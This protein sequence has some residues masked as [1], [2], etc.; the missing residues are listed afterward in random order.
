LT[1][2]SIESL[3]SQYGSA[4][5]W[6]VTFTGMIAAMTMILSSTMVNVAVPSIMGSYGVGQDE[7]Q[8]MATAFLATMTASQLLGAWLIGALGY[9]GGYLSAVA[10]FIAG[11]FLCIVAPNIDLLI[12]GRVVQGFAAGLVQPVAM[13][14][15]FRVFP[16]ERRGLA[17]S[18][19]GMG[20][21]IAPIMGPVVGGVTIDA[22]GWRELFFIPLPVTVLALILGSIFFPTRDPDEA[23]P[24]F[25]WLGY[26]LLVVTIICL[27]TFIANGQREGWSSNISMMRMVVGIVCAAA[28]VST[29]LRSTSPLLDF[30]LFRHPQF[31]AAALLGFVFGAGNF[32]S[33]YAIPV[34]VQ[35][36]QYFSPTLAGMVTV[37]AGVVLMCLFPVGGRLVDALPVH[38]LAMGGLLVFAAGTALLN[39]ADANTAFWTLAIYVIVGRIGLSLLMPTIN[40]SAL[41]ALPAE[42]LNRGSGTIN[43][44]RLLGGACGVNG[45]VV[46]ME[47]RAEFHNVSLTA[48][49]TPGNNVS[50]ELLSKVNE[51]L[52]AA[53]VSAAERGPGALHYLGQVIEAQANTLGFQDGFMLLTAVFLGALLPAWI[54]GLSSRRKRR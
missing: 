24:P 50:Q 13:V 11:S 10:I 19:Y 51:L 18:V 4:Y 33:T 37:P 53:G 17:M 34:F 31:A 3:S 44:V 40:V 30:S 29:Q 22:M 45:F 20:I 14:M 5:R 35:T 54:L 12:V 16:Q 38:Y 41:R 21:M 23:K 48:T 39:T 26:A 1:T 25:D 15:I 27:M 47:Q 32:A 46:F 36:V 2:A 8:W 52:S 28:F 9:R 6:I 49:Q 42:Q 7:A 43:F